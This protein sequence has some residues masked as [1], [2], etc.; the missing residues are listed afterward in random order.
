MFPGGERNDTMV[1]CAVHGNEPNPDD[2]E[3]RSYFGRALTIVR[4]RAG[5]TVRDVA[6][7]VGIPVATAGDYFAGRSLPPVKMAA[8]LPEILRV[9]GVVS[10]DLVASWQSALI[11]IRVVG[12]RHPEYAPTPYRGLVSYRPEHAQWLFGRA[13]LVTTLLARCV[14]AR[15]GRVPLAVVGE[16]GA[17]KTS[18][19]LAGLIPALR[20]EVAVLGGETPA[21]TFPQRALVIVAARNPC[22]QLADQLCRVLGAPA[23]VVDR[24]L[25]VRPTE[26]GALLRR[27]R[28]PGA[29][30][31]TL[32]VDQVEEL[33]GPGADLTGR[34][35]FLS[36]LTALSAAGVAVVLAV[37]AEGRAVMAG[38][39]LL[40]SALAEPLTV[41]PMTETELAEAIEGPARRARVGLEPGFV[42]R[43]VRDT[44]QL[45]FDPLPGPLVDP[46]P[47][48]SHA[49]LMTWRRRGSTLTI[50]DYQAVGGVRNAV[51]RS[52][53]LAFNSLTADQQILA[54][55]LFS[56]L[57]RVDAHPVRMASAVSREEL[58]CGHGDARRGETEQILG[59]FAAANLLTVGPDAVEIAHDALLTA[60]PRAA[61]LLADNRGCALPAANNRVMARRS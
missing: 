13:G 27:T 51:R 29:P 32:L 6:K 50:A 31:L 45:R 30:R 5:L 23:D 28:Q 47:L 3:D 18:V 2:I 53:E 52:A 60:W 19:L 41:A 12:G 43:V 38:H 1:G 37:R 15:R 35:T 54:A 25:H 33:F 55:T 24:A 14:I 34:N 61:L 20:G 8:V 26:L 22:R 17:G 49:L 4:E 57:V 59:R 7:A 11:R 48:L 9:C 40:R 39:P 44:M 36:A 46:L 42:S 56:R 21:K 10:P 58:G 16:S